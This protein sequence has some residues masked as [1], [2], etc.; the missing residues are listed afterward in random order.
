MES[1]VCK[2]CGSELAEGRTKWCSHRCYTLMYQASHRQE[3]KNQR[4]AKRLDD[5]ASA[6]LWRS[7]GNAKVRG[8]SNTL[9]LKDIPDIPEFCPVFPWIRLEYRVG[10]KRSDNSPSLDRIDNTRGYEAGNVRIVSHRANNL[11]SDATLQ[12]IEH[13]FIDAR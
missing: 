2:R 13:L 7:R 12:E 8:I 4:H 9:K 5:P 3:M 1:R 10:S 6:I 11:K